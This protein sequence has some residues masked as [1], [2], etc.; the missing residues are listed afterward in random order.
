MEKICP[1]CGAR[2]ECRHDSIESCHCTSVRL[3]DEQRDYIARN[4]SGCLCHHCL[5]NITTEPHPVSV[6]ELANF[7]LDLSRTLMGAGAHTSRVVRNVTRIA[8]SFGYKV[9]MTIFQMHITMT[10]R[11]AGDDTIR[12][13]SVG[14][15]GPAAF[16]FDIISQISSLS[17]EAHDEHLSFRELTEKYERIIRKPRISRWWVLVLVTA[18]NA[19]FCR[20]FG[21][22]VPAMGLVA[23]AT[24]VGFSYVRR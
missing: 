9:D 22:D 21:G 3:S 16:N 10:I 18:A 4:Y 7:L 6:R 15:I 24:F 5:E 11:H 13:T 23:A 1:R 12:R 8:E 20:L 2:F 14:K 17:W 19:C